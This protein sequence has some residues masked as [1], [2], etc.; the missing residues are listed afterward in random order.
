MLS[1]ILQ[2]LGFLKQIPEFFNIVKHI[3]NWWIDRKVKKAKIKIDK[4]FN[5]SK[6]EKSTKDLQ[7]EIGKLL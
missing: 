6:K 1:T 2:I 3:R 4:A 7:E 5:E